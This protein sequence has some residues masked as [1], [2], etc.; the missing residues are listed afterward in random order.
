[1]P[2][3]V[4][5]VAACLNDVAEHD[6]VDPFGRDAA[7]F[8][9]RSCGCHGQIGGR[10]VGERAAEVAEGRACARDDHDVVVL[11]GSVHGARLSA[12]A[13]AGHP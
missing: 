1:M 4:N 12:G 7:A 9:G 11:N 6:I 3:E 8:D 5:R 2:G 13:A 10:Q